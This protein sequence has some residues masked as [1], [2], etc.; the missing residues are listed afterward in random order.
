[1]ASSEMGTGSERQESSEEHSSSGEGASSAKPEETLQLFSTP[2][3]APWT[4]HAQ[5]SFDTLSELTSGIRTLEAILSNED[6]LRQPRVLRLQLGYAPHRHDEALSRAAV[7]VHRALLERLS[8]VDSV[9]R[10]G[11]NVESYFPLCLPDSPEVLR[12][13]SSPPRCAECA[14]RD[15][16]GGLLLSPSG[17]PAAP[18]AGAALSVR[19][20]PRP[21]AGRASTPL[22]TSKLERPTIADMV[23]PPP[24]SYWL[25]RASEFS[26]ISAALR[27]NDVRE[28]WDIGGGNGFLALWLQ[29]WSGIP[30]RVIEPNRDYLGP[31]EVTRSPLSFQEALEETDRSAYPGALLISWPPVGE[32]FQEY[33]DQVAPRVLLRVADESGLCGRQHRFVTLT[34]RGSSYRWWSWASDDFQRASERPHHSDR[35]TW[36]LQR[37]RVQ[38]S[39]D[40]GSVSSASAPQ[41]GRLLIA[42]RV[43][44][45]ALSERE[46]VRLP[47]EQVRSL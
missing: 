23:G 10:E 15:R 4:L 44:W 41:G 30:V 39:T 24:L 8:K 2:P 3:S 18:T 21:S 16:C 28:V 19:E 47:W 6:I 22:G 46:C 17:R 20:P 42:G 36:S 26:E 37:W 7:G 43:P 5:L 1:M 40:G 9:S 25:P 11:F 14:L 31:E 35:P 45:S 13:F 34:I 32:S 33:V 27:A 29:R 38:Q 12:A